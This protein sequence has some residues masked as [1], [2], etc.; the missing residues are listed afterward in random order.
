MPDFSTLR[1]PRRAPV[2]AHP[3]RL[4]DIAFAPNPGALRA[5]AYIPSGLPRRAPLVVVL[6]GCTQTAAGYDHAA[7]WS[8][9]ADV[10]GFALLFPEQQ[11]ANNPNRCFNWFEPGD[12]R[13][14]AG[15]VA[16][17]IA[18]IERMVADRA[19]DPS[20]VFVTGLSAGG[21]MAGAL[22]ATHP[23]RFAAGAIIAGLPFGCAD[24]VPAALAAM[25]G[26]P[27]AEAGQLG[28]RVRAA[29]PGGGRWP[30]VSIWHGDADRT[31]APVNAD[32]LVRQWRNVHGLDAAP[33][34]TDLID[35]HPRRVWHGADRRVLVEDIRISGMGHGAPL[36]TAGSDACGACAPYMLEVG[37]SSTRHIA[38][39]FELGAAG[40]L[41]ATAASP[42][43]RPEASSLPQPGFQPR[44]Q[45]QPRPATALR[46][47]VAKVIEDALRTARLLR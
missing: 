22:L 35:G 10:N 17:I 37:V 25:R 16:S 13:R 36:A 19:L 18:M 31:V 15:E 46:G 38:R 42:T 41:R 14:G 32:A 23:D 9:L 2:P 33:A 34:H 43:P 21:A 3:D 5:R 27:L 8:R 26:G 7:G 40:T 47:N 6:H 12:T 44:P 30:R 4:A 24:A 45:P 29:A 11:P 1:R 20:K 39:F 28:D